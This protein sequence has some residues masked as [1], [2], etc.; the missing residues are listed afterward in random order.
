MR[1]IPINGQSGSRQSY[2]NTQKFDPNRYKLEKER[3]SREIIESKTNLCCRRCC[4]I[5]NWKVE[6]GK[7]T[8]LR[9]CKKCNMCS[10]KTVNLAYHHICQQCA[11]NNRLC[12]KCQKCPESDLPLYV[13]GKSNTL[14]DDT[15]DPEILD[16]PLVIS[17][18]SDDNDDGLF[19]E[20]TNLRGLDTR[21][22]EKQLAECKEAQ[23]SSILRRLRERERRSV[24]RHC[25]TGDDF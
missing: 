19:S 9:Q 16:E 17:S 18:K 3:L 8:P 10:Q 1:R 24:L 12:A 20:L 22:L 7:Y 5:I 11:K 15:I 23:E 2:L 14:D 13:D 21:A 4:E 6:Y 25:N